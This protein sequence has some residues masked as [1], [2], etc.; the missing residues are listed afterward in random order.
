MTRESGFPDDSLLDVVFSRFTQRLPEAGDQLFVSGRDSFLA[1]GAD[2]RRYRLQQGYKRAGDI[3]IQNPFADAYDRDNLI[4][5]VIFCYRHYIELALKTIIEEHGP[6]AGVS[7]GKKNHDLRRLWEIFVEIAAAF[8]Y[9]YS[10]AMLATVG[11]RIEE[12]SALDPGATAFRYACNVDGT[13]PTLRGEGLDLVTLHDVMNGIENFFEGADLD[14][15]HKQE[16]AS[17]AWLAVNHNAH[18]P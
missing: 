11:G 9:D 10:D 15:T 14:F 4:W 13:I 18:F 16:L 12:F 5:P 3:L 17:E 2:E 1:Q 8:G 7:L 6:F